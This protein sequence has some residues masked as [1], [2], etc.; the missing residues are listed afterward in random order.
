MNFFWIIFE[1][2]LKLQTIY[3]FQSLPDTNKTIP[4]SRHHKILSRIR[5]IH[6]RVRRFIPFIIFTTEAIPRRTAT[7]Q[8]ANISYSVNMRQRTLQRFVIDSELVRR[9]N[10]IGVPEFPEIA[11]ALAVPREFFSQRF[12]YFL[13]MSDS[14]D[15]G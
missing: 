11:C 12:S 8:H 5:L 7:M 10:S 14:F 1:I 9:D 4:G 2:Q 3:S 13:H 6:K 15:D